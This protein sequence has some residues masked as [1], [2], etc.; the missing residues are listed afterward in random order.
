MGQVDSRLPLTTPRRRLMFTESAPLAVELTDPVLARLLS[1]DAPSFEA[2]RL[3]RTKVKALDE[4]RP[5]RCIGLVSA[6]PGDGTTTMALGLAAALAQEPGRR[7]LVVEAT[8]REPALERILGLRPAPGLNQWLESSEDGTV[9]LRHLKPWGFTL[10]SGGK[11]D[12]APGERLASDRMAHLVSAV[13]D[14]FDFVIV[15]CPPLEPVADSLVLQDMLDGFLF[16]VRARHTARNAVR[17]ACSHLKPEHVR[18][19]VFNDREEILA[20]WL[21][22]RRA[23]T[24][25]RGL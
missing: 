19:V 25:T 17:R 11:P 6:S 13:R 18:G 23:R 10:L 20:G 22:R 16:V 5:L 7:V 24:K 12:S 3:L 1:P 21:D 9:L 15:D 14:A 2:F 8:V 4:Q